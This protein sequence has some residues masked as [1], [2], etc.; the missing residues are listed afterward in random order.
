MQINVWKT[1]CI[2]INQKEVLPSDP[3]VLIDFIRLRALS[4]S[5]SVT[6]GNENAGTECT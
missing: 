4:T 1:D 5:S 2:S 3:L 6:T